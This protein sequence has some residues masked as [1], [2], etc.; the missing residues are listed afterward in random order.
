MLNHLSHT[1]RQIIRTISVQI[2]FSQTKDFTD[3]V[4]SIAQSVIVHLDFRN[5]FERNYCCV[6]MKLSNLVLEMITLF[7]QT[8]DS[9]NKTYNFLHAVACSIKFY[10]FRKII[11][12]VFFLISIFFFPYLSNYFFTSS[13]RT[14]FISACLR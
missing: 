1:Y 6:E 10:L 2:D 5:K 14:I 13:K 3:F 8:L 11:Y 12:R 4:R 9:S 7:C